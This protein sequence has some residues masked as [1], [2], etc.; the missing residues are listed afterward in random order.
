MKSICLTALAVVMT[1]TFAFASC[2]EA[3]LVE[4]IR[5]CA[6]LKNIPT[7]TNSDAEFR[8]VYSA[9]KF[10]QP[11]EGETGSA[12]ALKALRHCHRNNPDRLAELEEWS[13]CDEPRFFRAIDLALPRR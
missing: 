2:D 4:S 5:W 13:S 10:G 9:I 7:Y 1:G 8:S 6:Q 11:F 12:G 3:K